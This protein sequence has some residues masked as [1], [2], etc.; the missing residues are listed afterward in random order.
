MGFRGPKALWDRVERTMVPITADLKTKDLV[1]RMSHRWSALLHEVSRAGGRKGQMGWYW[2]ALST[3]T[4]S[5]ATRVEQEML[6]R[7]LCATS[8]TIPLG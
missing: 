2:G 8:S 6:G 7:E 3:G 5:G 1:Q 4:L